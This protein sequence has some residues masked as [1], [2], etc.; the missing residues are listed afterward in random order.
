[1][2]LI[3]LAFNYSSGRKKM[4]IPIGLLTPV[5]KKAE[6]YRVEEMAAKGWTLVPA[7]RA[8]GF[9]LIL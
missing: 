8:P 3:I 1:M 5:L 7:D 9:V 6:S 4:V 2:I